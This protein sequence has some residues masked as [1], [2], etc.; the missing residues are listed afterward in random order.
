MRKKPKDTNQDVETPR[1]SSG[2]LTRLGSGRSAT[3]TASVD[4][5]PPPSEGWRDVP[6]IWRGMN[7]VGPSM[8]PEKLPRGGTKNKK[9]RR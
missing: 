9:K 7:E 5:A 8:R 2:Q 1:M 4:L 3:S 6:P